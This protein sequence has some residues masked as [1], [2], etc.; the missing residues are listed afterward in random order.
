MKDVEN[1]LGLKWLRR[2]VENEIWGIYEIKSLT[3]KQRRKYK[4]TASEISKELKNDPQNCKYVR[5]AV[6]E[7]VIKNC[8]GVKQC[9]DD[10]TRVDKEKQIKNFRQ[11]LAFK[12]NKIFETKEYSVIKQIKKVFIRQKMTDQY[13]VDKYFIDLFFLDHK[14]GIEINENG[15]F[16]RYDIKKQEREETIKNKSI[17]LIRI[18]PDKEGF[19]IFIKIGEIQD[20]IYESGLKIGEKLKKNRIIEDLERSAKLIKMS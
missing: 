20:F 15:H 7:E 19:N 5:N 4:R 1:G 11:L 8:R 17:A 14:L 16:Y 9:N 3:I 10:I 12:E 18:N 13:K 2:M 6:M